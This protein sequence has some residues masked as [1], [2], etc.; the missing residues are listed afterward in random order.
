[1]KIGNDI[2]LWLRLLIGLM[3]LLKEIFGD[4]DDQEDLEKNSKVV[5]SK[6]S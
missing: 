5:D 3:R 6:V 4:K 1:M 2:W